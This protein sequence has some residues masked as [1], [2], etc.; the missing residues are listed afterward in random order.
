MTLFEKYELVKYIA[1]KD[2]GGNVI[3]PDQYGKLIVS[4]NIDLFKKKLGLP[5]DFQLGAPVSREY[6]GA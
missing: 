4:A 6:I 3:A 1:N 5:E 2:Y